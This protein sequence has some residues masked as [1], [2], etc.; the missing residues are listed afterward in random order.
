MDT[1]KK[2]KKD[3]KLTETKKALDSPIE[4]P[5]SDP[6]DPERL[7]LTQDFVNSVGVKRALL[8][9]P[10]RKPSKEDWI[11]VHPSEAYRVETAVIEL[12]EDREIYLAD[13]V[14]WPELAT[15]VTFG[16]RA[17]F[18]AI[19]RQNVVFLWPIR[20]PGPDGRDNPWNRSA[21]E[22]ATVAM[23]N[24]ARVVSNMSLGAYEVWEST[25]PIPDPEWPEQSLR[26]LL[27]IAF[28]DR[29]ITSM[30]HPVLKRLRGEA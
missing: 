6:F 15:E 2:T 19:N 5:G 12:K 14:L 21:L 25:A 27:Q 18:T 26:E 30:D 10:V 22:A 29:F 28:K 9:V 13:P 7:R 8:T 3:S 24:W 1:P 16:P 23:N 11:R 17:L 4:A 20:L